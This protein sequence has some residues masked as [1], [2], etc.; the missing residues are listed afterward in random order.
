MIAWVGLSQVYGQSIHR[1]VEW[2]MGMVI[3]QSGVELTGKLSYDQPNEMVLLKTDVALKTF[4]IH[5]VRSFQFTQDDVGILRRFVAY[6]F[7]TGVT[8]EQ[9]RFFEVILSGSLYV[10]RR[11]TSPKDAS[12]S[13]LPSTRP[14]LTYDYLTDFSYYVYHQGQFIYMARFQKAI[15][16]LLLQKYP[17]EFS[18]LMKAM[19]RYRLTLADKIKLI[20]AYNFLENQYQPLP[21]TAN[22]GLP[23]TRNGYVL[24]SLAR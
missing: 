3:L 9:L 8:G 23:V 2:P 10:L 4:S 19:N 21:A 15:L 14:S 20:N 12:L 11:D 22:E 1:W 18:E 6:P 13:R 16:P 5:Q 24:D 7:R 17:Q